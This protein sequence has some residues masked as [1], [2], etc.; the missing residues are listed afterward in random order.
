MVENGNFSRG[1]NKL[2]KSYLDKFPK[3][4]LQIFT[5]ESERTVLQKFDSGAMIYYV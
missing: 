3:N 4:G 1:I 2:I 5:K